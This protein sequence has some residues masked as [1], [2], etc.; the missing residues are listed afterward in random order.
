MK[1]PDR[2]LLA[3]EN[4]GAHINYPPDSKTLVTN[5][6]YNDEIY[7]VYRDW[8]IVLNQDP[9]V[10][11]E[12]S[13]PPSII[14]TLKSPPNQPTLS[15]LAECNSI[16]HHCSQ[17]HPSDF[18]NGIP[19]ISGPI[20]E[21]PSHYEIKYTSVAFGLMD[22]VRNPPMEY[23]FINS[24]ENG[25]FICTVVHEWDNALVYIQLYK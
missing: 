19:K 21:A 14:G 22:I 23:R 6:E 12:F 2:V 3:L 5:L 17:R 9:V 25:V 20:K 4:A 1:I 13:P 10:F 11:A 16:I 15:I 18:K 7:K 24:L 8:A